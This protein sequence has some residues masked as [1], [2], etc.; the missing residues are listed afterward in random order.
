MHYVLLNLLLQLN[1][2]FVNFFN[3]NKIIVHAINCSLV[4]R[5]QGTVEL[6][7]ET[8]PNEVAATV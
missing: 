6:I 8:K 3:S 7:E 1:L 4:Q 5:N 2:E